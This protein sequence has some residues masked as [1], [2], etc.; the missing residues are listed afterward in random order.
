MSNDTYEFYSQ[1][2]MG[3]DEW[4]LETLGAIR[5]GTFLD[6]GCGDYKNLSNTLFLERQLD[7]RGIGIDTNQDF[8]LSWTTQR[9]S[10]FVCADAVTVDYESLLDAHRMPA[11]IDYLSIDLEPPRL[12]LDALRA[13]MESTRRFRCITFEHDDYRRGCHT[14]GPSRQLLSKLG[15][16]LVRTQNNQDDFWVDATI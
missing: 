4:V 15:Y 14:K 11:V 12:A 2:G 1:R 9:R 7:W 10:P 5:D 6:C 8:A 16:E 3:Q 13:V